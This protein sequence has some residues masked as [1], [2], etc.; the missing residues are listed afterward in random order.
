MKTFA[1]ESSTVAWF[2]IADFIARGEKERALHMYPLLMHSISDPAISLQLEG[3]ILLAFDDMAAL[4]R[5]HQAVDL[6]KRTGKIRQA[7]GVYEYVSLFVEDEIILKELLDL[8]ILCHDTVGFIQAFI[9]LSKFYL[10]HG[11]HQVLHEFV[12][13]YQET[14][15]VQF[16]V[17]LYANY[18]KIILLYEITV[19]SLEQSVEYCLK[20]FVHALEHNYAVEKE[21]QK[22]L[23]DLKV[24]N[25]E[26]F[27]KAEIYLYQ[28]S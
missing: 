2:K 27:K 10:D 21:F 11:Y 5:Y 20:L 1:S 12:E 14:I 9:K 19:D 13:V 3:D 22:F 24:L 26:L 23:S 4:E 17:V 8:Y 25:I 6:Y 15:P 18:L 16:F 7:I 28:K